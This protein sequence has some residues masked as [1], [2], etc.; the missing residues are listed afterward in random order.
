MASIHYLKRSN[1][2]AI[3]KIYSVNPSGETI[4]L[5]LSTLVADGETFDS[6]SVSVTVKEIFWGTKNNK[7]VDVTR[8]NGVETHGHYFFINAGSHEFTG[9]TDDVYSERDIRVIADGEFHC[10]LKLTKVSGYNS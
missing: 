3:V 2:E 7:H 10:I 4:D 9:F 1:H 8:W 6:G 5:A